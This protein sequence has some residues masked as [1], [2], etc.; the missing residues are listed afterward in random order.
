MSEL[1]NNKTIKNK[2]IAF[3]KQ[4]LNLEVEEGVVYRDTII[5]ESPDKKTAMQGKVY[6]TNDMLLPEKNTFKGTRVE[7]EFYFKGKLSKRGSTFAGD[8]VF[9]TNMG[10]YNIPFHI[11]VVERMIDTSMGKMNSLEQFTKLYQKNREEAMQIFFSSSFS[12][13]FLHDD[14]RLQTIYKSF[15]RARKKAMIIEEFLLAANMKESAMISVE[16]AKLILDAGRNTD[17]ILLKLETDGYLEGTIVTDK[18]QVFLSKTSFTSLDFEDGYLKIKVEEDPDLI[19]GTDQIS[20]ITA[21]QTIEVPVEWWGTIPV[22]TGVSRTKQQL[23]KLRADLMYNYLSFRTGG[24]GFDDFVQDTLHGLEDLEYLEK[25]PEWKLYRIHIN[26]M[27][28]KKEAVAALTEEMEREDLRGQGHILL[29]NYFLYLKALEQKTPTAI[30]QAVISIRDLYEYSEYKPEAFW[31]LL[32]LDREYVYNKRLQYDTI[33]MLFESGYNSSLLCF[34]ACDILN[35]NPNFMEELGSFEM[36]IFRWGLRYGYI[37]MALAQKFARL[38]L[39]VKYFKKSIFHMAIRLYQVEPDERFLLLICSLLIKGNMLDKKYHKYFKAGIEANLKLIGL[40]EFFIRS[41]DYD[42]YEIIPQRVLIYFTY[43]NSLD[44]KE[45][46]YLYVNIL[47]NRA[48]YAEIFG[49]Y[50]TKIYP[51]V[52]EQLLKGRIDEHFAYLYSTYLQELLQ[53]PEYTKALCDVMFYHR[54]ICHNPNMVGVYVNYPE[55]G[56]EKYYPLSGQSAK[57]EIFNPR[58]KVYFV[59]Q[60]EQRFCEG[61]DYQMVPLMDL[62]AISKE[63]I[64]ANQSNQKLMLM[65]SISLEESVEEDSLEMAKM[66]YSD[67]AY[68]P[69]IKEKAIEAILLYY[70]NH[71]DME[72]LTKWLERTDYSAIT[73]E[74]REKLIAYYLKA[75]MVENAFFGVELY[76]NQCIDKKQRRILAEFGVHYYDGFEDE[77]TLA[78]AYDC[79]INKQYSVRI[80]RYL[81]EYFQGEIVD[82]LILW[83]RCQEVGLETEILEERLLRQ[84]IYTGAHHDAVY[85]VFEHYYAENRDSEL[86]L[87]Y[88]QFVEE[89][90]QDISKLP[91]GMMRIIGKEISSGRMASS[92]GRIY[93]LYYFARHKKEQESEKEIIRQFISELLQ[94]D[95]YLPVYHVYEYMTMLPLEYKERM[96]FTYK[97]ECGCEVHLYYR[98]QDSDQNVVDCKLEEILPGRYVTSLYFY[99]NDRVDYYLE[100]NGVK[101]E[102]KESYRFEGYKYE[103]E[104]SR[105]FTLNQL[106]SQDFAIDELKSYLKNVFYI[107]QNLSL[108]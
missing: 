107:Q 96:F 66:V 95:I 1:M 6:S 65:Q 67:P 31:M 15:Q 2:N 47:K 23:K 32:Y 10:E 30:S 83:S 80:L 76:G 53:K 24:V 22:A 21:R 85:D 41:M 38:A 84:C 70:G 100:C 43:S 36:R 92:K 75:N 79:M 35:D 20:I 34:E 52:E 49:T 108:L 12:Q 3:S 42:Q 78:L 55:T 60:S 105:F 98:L 57:I 62:S 87:P 18:D 9:I 64:K 88:L 40:N 102:D 14:I 39:K 16:P 50:V 51:F 103:S 91:V 37:S 99:Q 13:V 29:Y 97:G 106:G 77:T 4:F 61:I 46:A 101:V 48:S 104:S 11:E 44:A 93:Y 69:W 94:K 5:L 56:K 59:N 71:N 72:G 17:E 82:Y 89:L 73:Y 25:N 33:K 28:K 58:S 86:V 63:W 8:F 26:S 45:K 90:Q 54:L 27:L 74:F 19:M 68:Q 7:I 81:L